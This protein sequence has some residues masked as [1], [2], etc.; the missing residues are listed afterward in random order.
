MIKKEGKKGDKKKCLLSGCNRK[1]LPGLAL[2]CS[3]QVAT[4]AELHDQA[5]VMRSVKLSVQSR[6]ERVIKHG[7]NLLLHLR[8]LQLLPYRKCL[9]VHHLHRI[10]ALRQPHHGVPYLAKVH[11]PDVA[12]PE[13][14][15][16]AEVL[17]TDLPL[18]ATE[19]PHD[20]PCSLVRLVGPR[21]RTLQGGG[22]HGDGAPAAAAAEAE[23]GHP[24]PGRF[25]HGDRGGAAVVVGF[26]S[27]GRCGGD[28]GYGGRSIHGWCRVS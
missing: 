8:P 11:V 6:Q 23:V 28:G 27:T 24:A 17:Q 16:Q 14:P 19:P 15:H 7:Q 21:V 3:V 5:R 18:V 9:S 10:K 2:A 12:A 22:A 13:P 25:R 20:L 4:G 1:A 26:I